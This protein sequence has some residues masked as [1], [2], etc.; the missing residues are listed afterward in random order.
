MGKHEDFIKNKVLHL[1]N[2]QTV[3]KIILC[4]VKLEWCFII[5]EGVSSDQS[6]VRCTGFAISHYRESDPLDLPIY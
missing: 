4:K 2:T 1:Q 6:Q 5:S 3:Y